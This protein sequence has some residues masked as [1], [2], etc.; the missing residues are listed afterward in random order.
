MHSSASAASPIQS[1]AETPHQQY[2]YPEN[3][4]DFNQRAVP[5]KGGQRASAPETDNCITVGVAVGTCI[6]TRIDTD[7]DTANVHPHQGPPDR[8]HFGRVDLIKL[9]DKL[10]L[11]HRSYVIPF[12][13]YSVR[14]QFLR[15][16]TKHPAPGITSIALP[17]RKPA[18]HIQ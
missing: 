9:S 16:T 3:Q 14:I 15:R 1:I 18:F 6:D 11:K 13:D 4:T 10:P 5:Q 7:T 8:W 2:S 12:R 17:S